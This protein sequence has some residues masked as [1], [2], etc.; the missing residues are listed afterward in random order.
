MDNVIYQGSPLAAYLEGKMHSA[1]RLRGL[2]KPTL[3]LDKVKGKRNPTGSRRKKQTS[4]G[5]PPHQPNSHLHLTGSLY[6]SRRFGR[7]CNRRAKYQYRAMTPLELYKRPGR[8]VVLFLHNRYVYES[9]GSSFA[10]RT[11]KSTVGAVNDSSFLEQFRYIIVASQLL[12]EQSGQCSVKV[13]ARDV[14][15]HNEY[16]RGDDES[17]SAS[18]LGAVV[19]AL[20]AFGL[21][22]SAHLI[23]Q[24]RYGRVEKGNLAIVV[25]AS[26]AVMLY[27]YIYARSRWLQ[28]LRQRVIDSTSALVTNLR[29]FDISTSSALTFIQE[30]ELVSRGYRM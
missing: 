2:N 17:A 3:T 9:D 1:L 13:T 10:Q 12:N 21:A 22:C 23:S 29:A 27:V 25:I 6:F 19:A 30:V 24:T 15:M 14:T 20:C 18:V 4:M 16:G 8:Y 26:F 5:P 7:S 28:V 11:V